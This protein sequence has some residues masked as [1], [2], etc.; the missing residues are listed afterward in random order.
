MKR[1][2]PF[3][4]VLDFSTDVCDITSISLEHK[5]NVDGDVISGMFFINGDYKITDGDIRKENFNFE[6][7]FDIALGRKYNLDTL[8]VDI[9]DF[10][11][12]LIGR[13]KLKVNIDLYIDGEEIVEENLNEN[14]QDAS[15]MR[16]D[17]GEQMNN[18]DDIKEEKLIDAIQNDDTEENNN[19][20]EEESVL[21]NILNDSK[22]ESND[23]D[24]NVDDNKRD[25]EVDIFGGFN[26]NEEYVTYRVYR[27]SNG[28]TIDSIMDKYGVTR[29]ELA[30]YNDIS[31]IKE[32]D[33]LIIPAND[34]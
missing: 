4:N 14:F 1:I 29:D 32:G 20:V 3:N 19:V 34:K 21:N 13:N 33:K 7:P 8:V 16:N 12:E 17:L 26:E 24:N 15:D 25:N 10:R 27:V 28:D 23:E 6:L 2:V 30:D 5:I 11:Y 31:D 22:V 18:S 9:D